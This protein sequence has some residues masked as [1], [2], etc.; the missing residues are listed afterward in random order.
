MFG[1]SG[2]VWVGMTQDDSGTN[3]TIAASQYC[4]LNYCNKKDSNVTFTKPDTQCNYN[5]SGILCGACQPGLSLAL[6]S[7]RCLPCSN[8]YLALLIPFTLAGSALVGFIKFLDI[9]V[10]QGVLN[11]L[12]FYAN[13]IQ[14]NHYIYFHGDQLISCLSS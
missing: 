8:K 14:A 1:R 2:L 7:E 11:G 12:I 5:H 3:G 6:G 13:I 9:T 10:S 4:P